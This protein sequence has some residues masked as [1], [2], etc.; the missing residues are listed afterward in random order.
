[1]ALFPAS[2]EVGLLLEE[3]HGGMI[4]TQD[5]PFL[6]RSALTHPTERAAVWQSITDRWT[7]LAERLPSNSISRMLEGVRA[8]VGDVD[9]DVDAFLDAHP[10]P[11]GALVVAQHRERRLVNQRLR[12]RLLD[13]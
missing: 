1:L 2:T 11:Q 4:R 10:V 3:V 9:P 13:T 8:L 6:L 7:D 12:N 5:A